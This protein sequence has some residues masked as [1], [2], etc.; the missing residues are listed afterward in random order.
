M[1]A[2]RWQ[3]PLH[4]FPPQSWSEAEAEAEERFLQLLTNN[5]RLQLQ[6]RASLRTLLRT[7]HYPLSRKASR[8]ST[9]FYSHKRRAAKRASQCKRS[10]QLQ[11][12]PYEIN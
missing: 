2:T 3:F 11:L 12:Q 9:L 8:S 4:T 5:F 7:S 10:L 1:M 6:K